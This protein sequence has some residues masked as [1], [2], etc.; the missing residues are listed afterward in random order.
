L[1]AAT[2]RWR[3]KNLRSNRFACTKLLKMRDIGTTTQPAYGFSTVFSTVVEIL[4]NKPKNRGESGAS[5]REIEP[6]TVAHPDAA[7]PAARDCA[8]VCD[9]DVDTPFQR[10]LVLKIPPAFAHRATAGDGRAAAGETNSDSPRT[11]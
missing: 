1:G 5:T 10:R 3:P 11:T 2:P 6:G 8:R 4:G 7:G 9:R